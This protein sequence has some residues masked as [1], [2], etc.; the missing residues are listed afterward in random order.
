MTGGRIWMIVAAEISSRQVL[1]KVEKNEKTTG[2]VLASRAAST[3]QTIG[4]VKTK[5]I[6]SAPMS[7][8]RTLVLFMS[9]SSA[10][11]SRRPWSRE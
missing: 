5:V 6:T 11:S 1:V 8:K 9:A 4:A 3:I 2:N 7:F 10:G